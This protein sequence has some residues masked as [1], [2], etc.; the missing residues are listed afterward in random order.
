M[1]SVE[2]VLAQT[3]SCFEVIVVDDGSTDRTAELV[4]RLRQKSDPGRIIYISQEN[5]GPAAARNTGIRA[6]RYDLLAFLDSDDRLVKDKLAA[7]VALMAANPEA[8]ISHTDEIWFRRGVRLNPKNRHRKGGGDLFARCLE[9]CVV[10]MSTVM[11]RRDFFARAGFFNEDFFCCEDYDLWLRASVDL[12]FLYLDRALTIKDG[13]RG[14]QLSVIHRMGMDKLR[15]K[16]ITML[17]DSGRLDP[18][19]EEMAISELT[20]KCTIYGQGCLKHGRSEE[21]RYYLEL[22]GRGQMTEDRRQ[23]TEKTV[24]S[25]R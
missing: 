22:P 20:R 14:D 19:Q 8:L 4:A 12:P 3:W 6:A 17:L 2:S 15:I 10:G 9:L 24:G 11:A 21:G 16:S 25:G 7:Q 18:Q 5:Q 1:Q 13:G 23:R